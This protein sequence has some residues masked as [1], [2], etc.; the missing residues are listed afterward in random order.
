MTDEI[1]SNEILKYLWI[2]Q[3][4]VAVML[5]LA[6]SPKNSHAF[7]TLLRILVTVTAIVTVVVYKKS[8]KIGLGWVCVF[9]CIAVLFNPIVPIYLNAELWRV[10][11]VISAV[12]FAISIFIGIPKNLI[13]K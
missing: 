12:V 8:N 1:K 10:I 7:Y 2:P 5:L 6:V 3:L 9:I 13:K 11:D 4:I